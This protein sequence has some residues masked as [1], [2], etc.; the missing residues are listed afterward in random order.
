MADLG[1]QGL[2]RH[3]HVRRSAI[4]VYILVGLFAVVG[5]AWMFFRFLMCMGHGYGTFCE[6]SFGG[7]IVLAV[8]ITAGFVWMLESIRRY[9]TE[10]DAAEGAQAPAGRW[11]RT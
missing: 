10:Q 1:E 4:S 3:R 7:P 9:G 2:R 8:A 11:K 6:L 5:A